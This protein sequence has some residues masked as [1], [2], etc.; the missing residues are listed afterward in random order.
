VHHYYGEK[1]EIGS[2][3]RIT[4]VED[5]NWHTAAANQIESSL[6]AE[7]TGW[8]DGGAGKMRRRRAKTGV[9]GTIFWHPFLPRS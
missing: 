3:D 7:V 9:L 2:L 1:V 8:D 6:K 4:L 5:Q